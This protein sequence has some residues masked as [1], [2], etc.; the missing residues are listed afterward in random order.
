MRN[1]GT[2]VRGIR[3]PI[4]KK[5][6]DLEKIVVDCIIK[7]HEE[8]DI[9]F[10]DKDVL[11][12]TE[13]LLARAQGNFITVDNIAEDVHRKFGDTVGVLFPIYSRNRFSLILKGIARGVEK[14]YVQFSLPRDEVGNP[15]Y[16]PFTKI[17]YM[18]FYENISPNI[19]I[20]SSNDLTEILKYTKNILVAGIHVREEHKKL[21]KEA[22]GQKVYTLAEIMN[23]PINGSGYNPE[24]GLLGSNYSTDE[25]LKLFPINGQIFVDNIQKELKERT[26]KNIEVMIYGDGAFKDPV[27]RN[28]GIS[29]PCGITCIY[30]RFRRHTT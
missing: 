17:D 22:G 15:I 11:A 3:A 13:S 7:A 1:I 19:E 12:I 21:I 23:E 10:K 20:I 27:C 24:Y 2:I 18:E 5:G 26:G 9:Q 14:V 30:K 4:I 16:N 29:R 6:D 28:L 25:T 8:D